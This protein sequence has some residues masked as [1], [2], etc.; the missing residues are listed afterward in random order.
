[1]I[2]YPTDMP[3]EF[4]KSVTCHPDEL[5]G[6]QVELHK[7]AHVIFDVSNGAD[8]KPGAKGTCLSS[9]AKG[10]LCQYSCTNVVLVDRMPFPQGNMFF[11]AQIKPEP[12]TI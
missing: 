7:S 12:L 2:K 3:V 9:K 5:N 8:V 1:M 11:S 10:G 6:Q 4:T